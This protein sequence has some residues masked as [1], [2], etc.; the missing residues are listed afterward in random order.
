MLSQNELESLRNTC[1]MFVGCATENTPLPTQRCRQLI[2][3]SGSRFGGYL[4]TRAIEVDDGDESG[5]Y[6]SK[7]HSKISTRTPERIR[8]DDRDTAIPYSKQTTVLHEYHRNVA[9]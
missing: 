9:R 1:T 3:V 2:L 8:V 4:E 5:R 6:R 7:R